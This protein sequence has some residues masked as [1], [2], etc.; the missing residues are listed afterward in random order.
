MLSKLIDFPVQYDFFESKEETERKALAAFI[1][2]LGDKLERQRKS[3]FAKIG[4]NRK[5]ID[6]LEERLAILERNICRK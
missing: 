4:E 2:Q 6:D 1:K 5:R 3:Q